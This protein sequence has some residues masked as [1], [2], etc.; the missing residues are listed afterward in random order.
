MKRTCIFISAMFGLML[1]SG[2]V[3]AACNNELLMDIRYPVEDS[4]TNS[5]IKLIANVSD[6]DTDCMYTLDDSAVSYIMFRTPSGKIHNAT[7]SGLTPGKHKIEVYCIREL[8]SCTY[9]AE[10]DVEWHVEGNSPSIPEYPTAVLPAM[11]SILSLGL[12]KMKK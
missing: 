7:I 9:E 8:T 11:L 3:M 6:E 12:V 10:K 5:T 4:T 2:V 1:A